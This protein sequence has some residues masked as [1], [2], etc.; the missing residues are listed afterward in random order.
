MAYANLPVW[1]VLSATLLA[2]Y[3]DVTRFKVYNVLT[4]PLM[5][6]ALVFHSLTSGWFGA[7]A[8]AL[9]IGLAFGILMLPYSI[10][11][12]GA[13][14]LK[15]TMAIGAWLGPNLIL[16]IIVIGC[17]AAGI[18][19]FVLICRQGGALGLSSR[20]R[21]MFLRLRAWGKAM[22]ASDAMEKVIKSSEAER[23]RH[24]IPFSAMIAIGVIITIA[25]QLLW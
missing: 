24:L 3:T 17:L 19:A 6:G 25:T 23:R 20:L 21:L 7:G 10:G 15:F 1:V 4:I 14:D 11:G 2:A 8:W 12:L 22:A 18:Y 13:G 16:P 5:L 9:G